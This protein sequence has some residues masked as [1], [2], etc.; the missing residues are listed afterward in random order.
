MTTLSH[1]WQQSQHVWKLIC[2]NCL[3]SLEHSPPCNP[4]CLNVSCAHCLVSS[5]SLEVPTPRCVSSAHGLDA[6]SQHWSGNAYGSHIGSIDS[7]FQ[8]IA[9]S[10]YR[11]NPT[12]MISVCK[13]H[14]P[15]G[16]QKIKEAPQVFDRDNN[17]FISTVELRHIM[18]NLGERMTE[19]EADEQGGRCRWGWADWLCRYVSFSCHV[20]WS[21][22]SINCLT[23]F[24]RVNHQHLI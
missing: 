23:G 4:P 14:G 21:Y 12:P 9:P 22:C 3:F 1:W 11:M 7:T 10:T 15:D 20:C 5:L 18:M 6:L 19:Q 8:H 16:K 24:V 17:G 2:L 13:V